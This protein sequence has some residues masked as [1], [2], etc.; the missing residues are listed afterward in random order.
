MYTVSAGDPGLTEE[1]GKSWSTGLVWDITS[2]MSVNMDYWDIRLN[3]AIDR[4]SSSDLLNDEA[5]CITGKRLDGSAFGF[6]SGSAYCQAVLG[7]ITRVPE[8][9]EQYGRISEITSGPINQSYM[10]VS[11]IDAALQYRL[12]TQRFGRYTFRMDWSHTLNSERQVRPGDPID[13]D[14]RDDPT[15]LDFRSKA[16]A[17][18]NWRGGDWTANLSTVRY[19]SLPKYNSAAGRTDAFYLWNTNVGWRF[20]KKAEL[21]FYINNLFND[22]HPGDETNTSFPYFYEAFNPVGREVALQFEYK[23]E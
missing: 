13:A 6:G 20:S 8:A 5:G 18:M 4:I 1:T 7:L 2:N 3:G 9:G 10:R 12:A 16:K 21:R 14:W 17:S 11:G 19:G 22:L 23:F 15:N